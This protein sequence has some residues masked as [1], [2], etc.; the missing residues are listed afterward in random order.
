MAEDKNDDHKRLT[1]RNFLKGA[2]AGA[3]VAV[4]AVGGVEE[5]RIINMAPPAAPPAVTASLSA[6]PTTI[7][8]GGSVTFSATPG[9]GTA[10][11][12]TSIDCGDGTKLTASGA[13]T[14]ASLG[15]Y[16]ALLTV[17]DSTGAKAYS[18][19]SLLVSA[20]PAPLTYTQAVI[21]NV[22]GLD[23]QLVVD[24]RTSLR[25]VIRDGLGLTGT[26]NGCDGRGECGACTV[27]A[28]G[29]P[30]LS[31]LTLATEAQGM[32]VITVEGLADPATGALSQLQQTFLA[33][34][35]L[36]CGFC[37]PGMLLL[38]KGFLAEVPQPTELQVREAMAGN[39][40]RCGA[41][42]KIVES[43]LATSTGGP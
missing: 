14:Y 37:T 38:A 2:G 26:K 35:G 5:Y 28:D 9:G 24:N 4:V 22:N 1:R 15:T 17:T 6:S 41:N 32:K 30:I 12:T 19:V 40:C 23:R 43:I 36:Q 42:D 8:A 21:L 27:L 16:T 39:L 7:Q 13:H 33:H 3:A 18:M 20:P 25:D 34:D 29:K 11:Y 31:C 10:P